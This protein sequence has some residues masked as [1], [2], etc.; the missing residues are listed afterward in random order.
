MTSKEFS[1]KRQ[2]QFVLIIKIWIYKKNKNLMKYLNTRNNFQQ[3]RSQQMKNV[4]LGNNFK[5]YS[6]SSLLVNEFL[7]NDIRFGDSYFGRLVNSSIQMIKTAYKTARIPFIL[8]DLENN[9][10]LMVDR[11]SYEQMSKEY[12]TLFLKSL[13]EEIKSCCMSTLTDE[14]KLEILISWD[15]VSDTYN[16]KY[17]LKDIPGYWVGKKII[18]LQNG[19][20]SMIQRV[21]DEINDESMKEKLEDALNPKI[22]KEFLDQLSDFSDSLRIYAHEVQNPTTPLTSITPPTGFN[23][24]LAD[25]L[26]NILTLDINENISIIKLDKFNEFLLENE[27]TGDK[28]PNMTELKDK[29]KQLLM[30][31]D[32]NQDI[33][34]SKNPIMNNI[35]IILNKLTNQEL[36]LINQ[37]GILD[38]LN[39]L[40]DIDL[41]TPITGNVPSEV[42]KTTINENKEKI[43]SVSSTTIPKFSKPSTTH[44]PPQKNVKSTTNRFDE[45]DER[46]EKER[47]FN[48]KQ[49]LAEK[50][51]YS[52]YINLILE[53]QPGLPPPPAGGPPMAPVPPAPPIP[54]APAVPPTAPVAPKDVKSLWEAFFKDVDKIFPAK[55]TQD[56]INKLKSYTPEKIDLVYSIK[57]KPNPIIK[58]VQIFELA[59]SV[60]TTPMI[61]SGRENGE[62]WGITFRRY[63]HVGR[64]STGTAKNPGPGPWVHLPL[65][66]QW[67][68][69][70]MEIISKP[71]FSNIFNDIKNLIEN[72]KFEYR[73][74]NKI[75]EKEKVSSTSD[76]ALGNLILNLLK[77]NNQGNFTEHAEEMLSKLFGIKVSQNKLKSTSTAVKPDIPIDDKDK[78]QNKFFWKIFRETSFSEI[79]INQFF[80]FPVED[81]RKN[82]NK[83]QIIFLRPLKIVGDKIFIKF[84]FDQQAEANLLI[85]NKPG[86]P[87]NIDWSCENIPNNE[88]YF[89]IMNRKFI[90]GISLCYSSVT[91]SNKFNFKADK[92]LGE[93]I[94]KFNFKI[95]NKKV[96]NK[97]GNEIDIFLS[98]LGFFDD[99]KKE[100]I[101]KGNNLLIKKEKKDEDLMKLKTDSDENI[102]DSLMK[103]GKEWFGW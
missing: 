71:E 76:G 24:E 31:I 97:D 56:D 88:V 91:E 86:N 8:N 58:I 96:K 36:Q 20:P 30:T 93:P 72:I 63:K 10:R 82:P 19:E 13:L 57:K 1:K 81:L 54:P 22:V 85:K 59:N 55:L 23:L 47:G 90:D 34:L 62:V 73:G 15:G 11:I 65:Y 32:K 64:S 102:V 80:A 26:K 7:Q 2:S 6:K 27:N 50:T 100:E 45:D 103:K 48:P 37:S 46:D 29:C 28:F 79:N 41:K 83:K 16:P 70:V 44:N 40:F 77:I 89:G 3:M 74:Y 12:P 84:T 14:E 42:S 61:P 17:P 49:P 9:L 75:N 101:P 21:L 99:S 51:L 35:K 94:S 38:K 4:V 39:K 95:K 25:V 78:E 5:E 43:N 98:R 67:K 69:G 92:L 68:K 52:K 33:D 66:R 87:K 53:E 18:K 60:Y